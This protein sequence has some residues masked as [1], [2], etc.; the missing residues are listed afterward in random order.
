MSWCGVALKIKTKGGLLFG[1]FL[2][3]EEISSNGAEVGIVALL[4]P[5]LAAWQGSRLQVPDKLMSLL[6]IV[7]TSLSLVT[8][9]SMTS[10]MS[11]AHIP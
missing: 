1:D 8:A 3:R 7:G 11:L 6:A 2:P 4:K 10:A 5:L 9:W